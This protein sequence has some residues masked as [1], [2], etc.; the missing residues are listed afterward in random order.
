MTSY[1]SS[2]FTFSLRSPRYKASNHAC[3]MKIQPNSICQ[4]SPKFAKH[5]QPI[6]PI[7]A[8]SSP[9]FFYQMIKAARAARKR[10]QYIPHFSM[11]CLRKRARAAWKCFQDIPH[12]IVDCLRRR[13]RAARKM[14][15]K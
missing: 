4:Y 2:K 1:P 14:F 11:D 12:L 7:F 6:L 10:F 3:Q 9:P 8:K 5:C 13:A 15:Q